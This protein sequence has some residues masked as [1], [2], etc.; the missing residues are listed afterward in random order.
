[1]VISELMSAGA[2]LMIIGMGTVFVFLAVLVA[3]VTIMS[4]IANAIAPHVEA[5][6]S[7][8]TIPVQAAQNG[9]PEA[10]VAAIV[11]AVKQH[12]AAQG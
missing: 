6:I 5:P 2:D 1:M 10:H 3:S 12:K 8:P 11:G 7:T 9:I 4:K